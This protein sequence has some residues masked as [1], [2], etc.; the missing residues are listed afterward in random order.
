MK[1]AAGLAP[2]HS[3][4][5]GKCAVT[6]K[7]NRGSKAD[8]MASNQSDAQKDTTGALSRVVKK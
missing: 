2:R 4:K 3:E 7:R 8:A 6:R 5:T 1:S